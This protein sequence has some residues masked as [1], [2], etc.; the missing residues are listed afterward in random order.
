MILRGRGIVASRILQRIHEVRRAHPD[1]PINV[2]H[3]MRA[4]RGGPTRFAGNRRSLAHHR[5][6]QRF[7]FPKAMFTGDLRALYAKQDADTR[8]RLLETLGGV[9][10]PP[11]R[12]W[13]RIVDEGLRTGWYQIAFGETEGIKP[14][15]DGRPALS[16][17][18]AMQSCL[19]ADFVIDCT[20]LLTDLGSNPLLC[21][22]IQHYA[23][24]RNALGNLDVTADFEV[25]ALRSKAGQFHAGRLYAAGA[26]TLGAAFAPVDSFL[27]LQY[28]ARQSVEALLS[29]RAPGLRPLSPGRSAR[30]WGRWLKGAQP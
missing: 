7:N 15:R 6:L 19:V 17:N 26:M 22:L 9:T 27:G 2:L 21:D 18:G 1:A 4:P 12:D 29:E 16:V 25:E 5:Q 23:P 24:P 8:L 10:T 28:A 14:A 11:R 3:L 20:G 13:Q 30:Q